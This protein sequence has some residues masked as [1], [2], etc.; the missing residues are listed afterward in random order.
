M[1]EMTEA[2]KT[3]DAE[4]VRE[5]AEA[6][7][8]ALR[9][10]E[11][12]ITP[13]LLAMYYGKPEIARALVDLGAPLSFG[14]ACAIGDEERAK[15]MLQRDRSVL[16]AKTAD[17]YP[18]LGLAIFFRHGALARFLIGEGAD[19]NAAADNVNN[20]APVHAAAGV[21]DIETMRALLARG[22]DV[23]A[24]QQ[25][26]YT[27]LHGAASRGDVDMGQLLIDNGADRNAKGSDGMTP[28]DAAR[29]HGQPAFAEWIERIG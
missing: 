17:G 15:T 1:S 27:A 18:P 25:L 3:G 20:V 4:R 26:D 11:N 22:A 19:V 2:I 6:H 16:D 28:A 14:E 29:Q 13:M 10:P 12:G 7:P 21:R 9:S 5:L 24:R 8:E 23:N